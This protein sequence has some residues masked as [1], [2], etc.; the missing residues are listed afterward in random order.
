MKH[1]ILDQQYAESADPR[2]PEEARAGAAAASPGL[3]SP[4]QLPAPR[5][6]GED[7]PTAGEA[8]RPPAAGLCPVTV[9][10]RSGGSAGLALTARLG[11][12]GAMTAASLSKKAVQRL[13]EAEATVELARLAGEIARHDA[14]YYGEDAPEI[15][16][17]DYDALRQRNAAIEA[18]Y[19]QLMRTDS[20]SRRVGSAPAEAFNKVRHAVPML[21]LGN[22]FSEEDVSD[23]MAR[24]RR[25]LGLPAEGRGGGH[26]RTE[27]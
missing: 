27:N 26:G 25:F 13:S 19:P 12:C 15:S 7:V 20:P 9:E 10:S 6:P 5:V 8:Q 3:P 21:S 4:D 1:R 24:V 22:A 11:Q 2:R 18:R 17:A 14:L 16:D 23:F